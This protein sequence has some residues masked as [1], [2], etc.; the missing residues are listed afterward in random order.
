MIHKELAYYTY[1]NLLKLIH[2]FHCIPKKITIIEDEREREANL[3]S[4]IKKLIL[5]NKDTLSAKEEQLAFMY[6][7]AHI[8]E[9]KQEE[10]K[11]NWQRE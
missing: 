3:W 11:Q 2:D 9:E 1:K 10:L 6:E 7:L 8:L 4:N 5:T